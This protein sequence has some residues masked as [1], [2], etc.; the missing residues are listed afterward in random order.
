MDCKLLWEGESGP[1]G[2]VTAAYWVNG[3]SIALQMDRN[4]ANQHNDTIMVAII[5]QSVQGSMTS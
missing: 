3:A 5:G 4:D 2:K 1:E